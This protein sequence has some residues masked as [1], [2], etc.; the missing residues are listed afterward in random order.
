MNATNTLTNINSSLYI[1]ADINQAF[2]SWI[3]FIDGTPKT[4]ETYTRAVRQFV[5][6]CKG[7]G[8]YNLNQIT[9]QDIKSYREYLKTSHKASTVQAYLMAVKQFYKWLEEVANVKNVARNVK[10]AKVNTDHKK[11]A[12]TPAQ[13]KMLLDTCDRSTATGAR[14]YAI[15]TLMLTCGLRTIEVI[16]ADVNDLKPFGNGSALYVQGK[17]H[18]EKDEPVII[19]EAQEIILRQY[20]KD[21]K[22]Q[23]GSEPLFTSLANKNKGERLTT[24]S[25]SR[26]V[27]QHLLAAGLDSERLTAHSLRHTAITQAL[28]N[29]ATI[30]E[31]KQYARH[32]NINTTL[33]Y[34]HN[35]EKQ[36]N[37]C[38]RLIAGALLD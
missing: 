2:N 13:A 1:V 33:I 10:G 11:D 20:L 24:K 23:D 7:L 19:A 16:R 28:V 27:K 9:T 34:S 26:L 31:A 37:P 30:Q 36:A 15:L 29:G 5:S 17:G 12:L 21:R 32:T 22:A 4:V 25:I 6:Y 38:A 35:L 3:D 14:D 18:D 8:F